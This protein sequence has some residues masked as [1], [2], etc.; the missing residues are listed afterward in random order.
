M[1]AER[2]EE[3]LINPYLNPNGELE[4]ACREIAHKLWH[5]RGCPSDTPDIDWK[6]AQELLVL[7]IIDNNEGARN[8]LIRLWNKNS[9]NCNN[10]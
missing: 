2:F 9:C 10:K 8:E 6:K 4:R 5:E 7:S 1:F 3:L